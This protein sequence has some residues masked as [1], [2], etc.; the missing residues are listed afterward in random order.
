MLP[1]GLEQARHC[2]AKVPYDPSDRFRGWLHIFFHSRVRDVLKHSQNQCTEAQMMEDVA[3]ELTGPGRD[4]NEP[5]DPELRALFQ[6]AEEV[7]KAVRARVT[8]DN[9]EVFRLA[10]IEGWLIGD[11]ARFLGREYTTVYRAYKRVSR[12]IDDERRQRPGLSNETLSQP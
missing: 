9:W 12:M 6:R 10:G 11:T 2:D 8:P 5:C 7:Q 4:D 1:G 3:C